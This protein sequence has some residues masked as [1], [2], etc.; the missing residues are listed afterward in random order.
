MCFFFLKIL[1]VLLACIM[2]LRII[3]S[4]TKE[5]I[6]TTVDKEMLNKVGY[7]MEDLEL[8]VNIL[9]YKMQYGCWPLPH[10]VKKSNFR[11]HLR[12]LRLTMSSPNDRNNWI[13]HVLLRYSNKK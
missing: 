12:N 1:A 4:R 7:K 13:K 6:E 8:K 2:L 9:T 11:K 3:S 10:Q 5:Y